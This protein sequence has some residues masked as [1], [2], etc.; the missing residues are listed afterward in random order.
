MDSILNSY[1]ILLEDHLDLDI[2][3][4]LFQFGVLNNNERAKILS[5]NANTNAVSLGP[6]SRARA[7]STL[8]DILNAGKKAQGFMAFVTALE[9][10]SDNNDNSIVCGHQIILQH[11]QKDSDFIKIKRIWLSSLTIHD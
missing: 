8:I 6:N 10:T 1:F 4:Y 11:V 5:I 3:D 7:I 2:C 9:Y